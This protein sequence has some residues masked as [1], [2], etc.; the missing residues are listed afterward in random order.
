MEII[1][2]ALEKFKITY[3]SVDRSFTSVEKKSLRENTENEDLLFI[4]AYGDI[5]LVGS[6]SRDM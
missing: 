4:L 1:P 2:H 3:Q 5:A 6:T